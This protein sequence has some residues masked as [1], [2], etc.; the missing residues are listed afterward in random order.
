MTMFGVISLQHVNVP[1]TDLERSRR[2][3]RDMLGFVETSR[4]PFSVNGIWLS[5]KP[6]QSIHITEVGQPEPTIT[7]HF[8][9]Q[10][11]DLGAALET[12]RRRGIAYER[13]ASVPGAGLQ[14]YF[15]DPDGNVI[16]L[17][18]HPPAS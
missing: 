9:L 13:A 11:L 14:A 18:E 6:G 17:I 12:L 10:V 5:I 2:F 15:R 4:P 8:A 1:S 3:Y 7:H 16:E